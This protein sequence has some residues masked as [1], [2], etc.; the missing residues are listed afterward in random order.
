MSVLLD[1]DP[2]KLLFGANP[3]LSPFPWTLKANFDG[4]ALHC[5]QYLKDPTSG[6]AR[7][8]RVVGENAEAF[9]FLDAF[10][11]DDAVKRVNQWLA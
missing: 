3:L 5:V 8:R 2:G 9:D 4:N 6:R 11:H 10:E 1:E 7:W